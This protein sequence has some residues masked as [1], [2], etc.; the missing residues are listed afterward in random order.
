[1]KKLVRSLLGA[2]IL[3]TASSAMA[4]DTTHPYAVAISTG[5]GVPT[6]SGSAFFDFDSMSFNLGGIGPTTP[7]PGAG[8]IF[9]GSCVYSLEWLDQSLA[10]V[11]NN[12]AGPLA[13]SAQAW[14]AEQMI[15][16]D[17]SCVMDANLP[18]PS[19]LTLATGPAYSP[20]IGFDAFG[21][22]APILSLSL[23]ETPFAE[24]LSGTIQFDS[25]L[26][27]ASVFGITFTG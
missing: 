17:G 6:F 9:P 20:S 4:L 3:A 13:I 8:A 22:I 11:G 10:Q 15:H 2:A 25:M 16:G 1:M 7:A 23:G 27:A 12:L 14:V 5:A 19:I 24:A 21:Q 26:A 18:V